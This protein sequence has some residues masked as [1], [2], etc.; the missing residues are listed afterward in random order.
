MA[1]ENECE[2]D[3]E[4]WEK[5]ATRKQ[6]NRPFDLAMKGSSGLRPFDV[7]LKY[8]KTGIDNFETGGNN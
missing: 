4:S 1:D 5:D 2:W 3:I 8:V 7:M 6:I